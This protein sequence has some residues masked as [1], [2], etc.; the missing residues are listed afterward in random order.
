MRGQRGDPALQQPKRSRAHKRLTSLGDRV[1]RIRPQL[2]RQIEV[3]AAQ[4]VGLGGGGAAVESRRPLRQL[5]PQ[6]V[7]QEV[8][9]QVVVAIR[10]MTTQ[11]TD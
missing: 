4:W 5:A 11:T 6:P 3:D 9:E 10:R 8:T 2:A 7:A 1:G